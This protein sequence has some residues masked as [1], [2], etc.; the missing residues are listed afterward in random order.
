MGP[1]PSEPQ[2][3]SINQ[4]RQPICIFGYLAYADDLGV[5]RRTGFYRAYTLPMARFVPFD[6]PEYEYAD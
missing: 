2:A 3:A 1:E 5:V 4:N 6:D